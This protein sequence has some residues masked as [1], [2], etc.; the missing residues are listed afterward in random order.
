MY[1]DAGQSI[2]C[3]CGGEAMTRVPKTW[4]SVSVAGPWL[5]AMLAWLGL[6]IALPFVTDA[7]CSG[8]FRGEPVG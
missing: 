1:G 3:S 4:P 7:R 8:R 2:W 5:L 6:L